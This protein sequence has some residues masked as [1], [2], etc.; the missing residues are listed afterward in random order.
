[1]VHEGKGLSWLPGTGR[2]PGGCRAGSARCQRSPVRKRRRPIVLVDASGGS[3]ARSQPAGRISIVHFSLDGAASLLARALRAGATR[4][5]SGGRSPH[6]GPLTLDGGAA[7]GP[8]VN[9]RT[10]DQ[11]AHFLREAE[12][13]AGSIQQPY[14]GLSTGDSVR[15][16]A[17][18]VGD[19]SDAQQHEAAADG[20]NT[21]QPRYD[22]DPDPNGWA[23]LAD[24][25]HMAAAAP[26]TGTAGSHRPP[27]GSHRPPGG[28]HSLAS[29]SGR[30]PGGP[31]NA[32]TGP[33]NPIASGFPMGGRTPSAGDFGSVS[34]A[35][36]GGNPDFLGFYAGP[37]TMA[38]ALV[39]PLL[40]PDSNDRALEAIVK[41]RPYPFDGRGPLAPPT[42]DGTPDVPEDLQGPGITLPG[43]KVIS[44]EQLNMDADMAQRMWRAG[45][46]PDEAAIRANFSSSYGVPPDD[47]AVDEVVGRAFAIDTAIKNNN[48]IP[49]GAFGMD[50]EDRL[51]ISVQPAGGSFSSFLIPTAV[52]PSDW[53]GAVSPQLNNDVG[54]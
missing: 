43:G 28:N 7:H 53:Y 41:E 51:E 26:H 42:A 27:G 48:P 14:A 10:S 1:M 38:A 13:P 21:R 37:A 12:F 23:A 52:W 17:P 2:N 15:Q 50:S 31:G 54:P 47:P 46:D 36:A 4:G 32:G 6:C 30:R 18:W 11:P 40:P 5:P 16:R 24:G 22:L 39:I 34:A 19:F 8:P 3:P 25:S 45:S 20:K 33:R 29:N 35:L 49:S 44:P 9:G